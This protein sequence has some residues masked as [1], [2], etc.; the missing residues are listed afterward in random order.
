M[1]LTQAETIER[2]GYNR[3]RFESQEDLWELIYGF[4]NHK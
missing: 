2:G 3:R 1:I 4:A